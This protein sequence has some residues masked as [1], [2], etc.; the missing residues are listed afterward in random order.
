MNDAA[1]STVRRSV[2]LH[3]ALASSIESLAP[4]ADG[5]ELIAHV[6]ARIALEHGVAMTVLAEVDALTTKIVLLRIQ[7]EAVV[8]ALW[9]YFAADDQI[10]DRLLNAIA[11]RF[12][13]DPDL[14][15]VGAMLDGITEH[16]PPTVGPMLQQL[17]S[18]LWRPMNSFVHT[19]IM[20]MKLALRDSPFAAIDD[21][22]RNSNG[23]S[24]IAAMLIA[25]SSGDSGL[26]ARIR[27]I[28]LEY[29]DCQPPLRSAPA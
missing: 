18:N 26:T 9:I 1:P 6:A 12:E 4:P 27:D 7:Y 11:E 15:S 10:V 2:L 13:K 28:Q 17:K 22:L 29:R 3:R 19:G 14:P 24:L 20:P 5:R 23:L 16:A 8:R 21:N 25:F